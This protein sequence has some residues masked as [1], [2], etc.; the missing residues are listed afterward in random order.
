MSM[1]GRFSSTLLLASSL[2]GCATGPVS[3]QRDDCITGSEP[4]SCE[5]W[6]ERA[7]APPGSRQKCYKGKNWPVRPRP[8]GE[9]QQFTHSYH[10]AHYWPLPYVCQDRQYVR[11]IIG[12]QESNGWQ[13][14][15]TIYHRHFDE[16][17]MLT[18]PGELHL[19]DILEVTPDAHRAV[20]VQAS[21]NPEIDNIRI[22]NIHQAIAEL[23]GGTD[24]ISVTTRRGRDYSRPASEVKIINDLYDSS[25]PTPRLGGSGGG[26]AAGAASALTP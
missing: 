14:Q 18:K 10:S 7:L 13:Q 25:I 26:G 19:I 1:I 5:W 6:S 12:I 23:S 8:T 3:F 4:G 17:H 9:R 15:T 2:V 11:D 24:S 22:A 20:Y 21:A 16:N